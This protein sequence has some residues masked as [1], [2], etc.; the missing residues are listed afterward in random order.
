MTNGE[1]KIMGANVE[2]AAGDAPTAVVTGA[3]HPT[4]TL[5][6]NNETTAAAPR[7][8]ELF[9]GQCSVKTAPADPFFSG[10]EHGDIDPRSVFIDY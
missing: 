10:R 9:S 8:V 3:Q 7:S 6:A 5:S 1:S 4:A 2:G